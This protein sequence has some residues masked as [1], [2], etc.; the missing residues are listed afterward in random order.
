MTKIKLSV[1]DQTPIR[2]GSTAHEALQETVRL[3]K[4]ADRLG[5]TR[6]W[7]SEH[8]NTVTLAG[9]S[10]EILIARLAAETQTIRLGSGGIMLPNHSTLKVAEN[11]RLL[12]ALYP[13]RIDLGIGRAPGGDR[14]TSHLLNPSNTFDP[15][16]YIRQIADLEAFLDDAPT[17]ATLNGK[18]RAI[19][20]IATRPDLWML[21]SSGESAYLAAHFGISLSYAQFINPTGGPEAIRTYRE[22]FQPSEHLAT[23]RASVGI[24]A[25][26][27]DDPQKVKEVQAVMDYRLHSFGKGNYDEIPSYTVAKDYTY[28]PAEWQQVLFNRQRMAVGN[29]EQIR[30]KFQNI[31]EEFGVDE[32]VVSTFTDRFEDRLRSYE[33]MADIFELAPLGVGPAALAG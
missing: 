1:L 31:A 20:R 21:T 7:L 24:F 33:L 9:A 2:R 17:P 11:F 25:Y 18:I 19:P 8:H 5:Y 13:G 23:P 32:I 27:S 3:A 15:Q 12:E 26:C 14:A 29:P 22:K 16:Q 6:Y 4:L 30:E 10:P 28:S